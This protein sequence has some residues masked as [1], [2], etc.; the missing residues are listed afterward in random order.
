MERKMPCPKCQGP[1]IPGWNPGT[2]YCKH[3]CDLTSPT[4]ST[5]E[6]KAL[7]VRGTCLKAEEVE[8]MLGHENVAPAA[9]QGS[10]ERSSILP[11]AARL[12]SA[13]TRAE[14]ALAAGLKAKSATDEWILHDALQPARTGNPGVL[15]GTSRKVGAKIE[16]WMPVEAK[17]QGLYT[18]DQINAHLVGSEV[19]LY[20]H[21]SPSEAKAWWAKGL[22]GGESMPPACLVKMKFPAGIMREG[23]GNCRKVV[24]GSSILEIMKGPC[25]HAEVVEHFGEP[26]T[27]KADMIKLV[28]DDINVGRILP[29]RRRQDI[30]RWFATEMKTSQPVLTGSMKL[31]CKE[32]DEALGTPQ[33]ENF[34][35]WIVM[36]ASIPFRFNEQRTEYCFPS[37]QEA[38]DWWHATFTPQVQEMFGRTFQART[39]ELTWS[40]KG[41]MTCSAPIPNAPNLLKVKGTCLFAGWLES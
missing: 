26:A 5:L 34:K 9:A 24:R 16:L 6:E 11:S 41:L 36:D 21:E 18:R 3:E 27:T 39:V 40:K 2:L 8:Q 1:T 25:L 28:N 20:L 7:G 13:L 35:A 32:L 23:S 17:S 37:A 30:E 33:E 31:S 10:T 14:E 29:T 12:D 4:T 38:Q 15:P 22:A 19:G